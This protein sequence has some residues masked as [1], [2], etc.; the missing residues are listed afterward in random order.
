MSFKG[1]RV[2]EAI[3]VSSPEDFDIQENYQWIAKSL[4]DGKYHVGYIYVDTPWY[5]QESE[6]TYYLR[7]QINTNW[8]ECV[9][10]K[11]SIKPYTIRNKVLLNDMRDMDTIFVTKDYVK[12]LSHSEINMLGTDIDEVIK[13]LNINN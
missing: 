4:S 10:E 2:S 9:I 13:K 12:D 11:D 8:E 3:V 5:S 1:R 7:Y 6:W